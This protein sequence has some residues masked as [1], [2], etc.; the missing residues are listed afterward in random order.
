[1]DGCQIRLSNQFRFFHNNRV[2]LVDSYYSYM[3]SVNFFAKNGKYL[4][5]IVNFRARQWSTQPPMLLD[6]YYCYQHRAT[7]RIASIYTK[8]PASWQWKELTLQSAVLNVLPKLLSLADPLASITFL[9][10]T[11][12]S[13]ILLIKCSMNFEFMEFDS[14]AYCS[15]I[16]SF[17]LRTT[18]FFTTTTP[19]PPNH[20]SSVEV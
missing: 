17:E 13:T 4:R 6:F 1:M 12:E 18:Q 16:V 14:W 3:L 15:P 20:S 11:N 10:F 19:L 9:L 2:L 8:L 5:F 7:C